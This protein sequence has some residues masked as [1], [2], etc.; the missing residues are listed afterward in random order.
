[1]AVFLSAVALA[2]LVLVGFL[3]T[4]SP[5]AVPTI[6]FTGMARVTFH[7]RQAFYLVWSFGLMAL[8]TAVFT[9]HK[10]NNAL[11][12]YVIG[13]LVLIVG[14]PT[15]SGPILQ[16]AYYAMELLSLLVATGMLIQWLWR[17]ESP[18]V[19]QATAIMLLFCEVA[20]VIGP[21]Q[22]NVFAGWDVARWMYLAIYCVLISIQGV[23]LWKASR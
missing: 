18:S 3:L 17:R 15:I 16:Q 4:G 14:Y 1:M 10:V 2:N 7:I 8:Y 23:A 22:S 6:P 21:W 11:Y 20:V 12:A 9:G 5:V 13:L 19:T